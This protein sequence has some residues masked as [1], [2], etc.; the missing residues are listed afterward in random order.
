MTC[1]QTYAANLLRIL[2]KGEANEQ[3]QRSV[4]SK[5]IL[6]RSLRQW[7]MRVGYWQHRWT[8]RADC[9]SWHRFLWSRL[10]C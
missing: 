9:R 5:T 7:R 4:T 6:L 1:R 10:R 3:H 2:T 8:G